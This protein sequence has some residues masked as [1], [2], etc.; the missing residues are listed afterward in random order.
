M[1][2]I[3]LAI[4]L[5]FCSIITNAQDKS[6]DDVKRF[7]FHSHG[8]SFQEFEQLKRRI[9]MYPQ[10]EKPKSST[11]TLQFGIFSERNRLI[12]GY[13]INA[14]SSLSGNR[15]KKSTA[16]SFWGIPADVGYN[17]LKSQRASLYPFA[18][19][20]YEKYKM[21]FSR[22]VSMVPFDSVLQTSTVQQG[23]ENLVFTNSF[24]VYRAGVGLSITSKKHV[25]NSIGLQLGYTGGFNP[26]EWKIN[27]LQTLLNS[28]KDKLSKLFASAIIRYRF[29]RKS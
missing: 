29:K 26:E 7:F 9:N 24:I 3:H 10:F 14:G 13:S 2:F 18:G 1:R 4:C 12:T 15:D 6:K 22:D 8:I 11:G 5:T 23:V 25:Q 21:V 27:K 16:T 20:G 19:L 17:L 28:P